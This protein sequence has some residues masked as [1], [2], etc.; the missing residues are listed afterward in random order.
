M[1]CSCIAII[2]DNILAFSWRD[3]K[4]HQKITTR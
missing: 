1:D 3:S 2:Y 4:K